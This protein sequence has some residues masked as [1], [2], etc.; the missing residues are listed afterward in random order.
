M[1]EVK[2]YISFDDKRFEDKKECA[3]YEEKIGNLMMEIISLFVFYDKNMKQIN[4]YFENLM[5]I[6]CSFDWGWQNCVYIKKISDCSEEALNFI[7]EY[8]GY[9][10]PDEIGLYKYDWV[11]YKWIKVGE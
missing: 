10:L 8:F 7:K 4:H 3:D 11:E 2:Y 6:L 5:G 9:P 1:R